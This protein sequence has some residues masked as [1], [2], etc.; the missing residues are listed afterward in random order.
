[1]S[2]RLPDEVRKVLW[3]GR[4]NT[5][6]INVTQAP[7]SGLSPEE[8][9]N[10]HRMLDRVGGQVKQQLE[11]SLRGVTRLTLGLED[12]PDAV[13]QRWGGFLEEGVQAPPAPL[14]TG[15]VVDAF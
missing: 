1:M 13:P 3:I 14:P 7:P 12:R 8:L 5:G 15:V 4:D 10:R 2:I 6:T 11:Q 9:D